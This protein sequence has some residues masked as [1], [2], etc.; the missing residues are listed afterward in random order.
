MLPYLTFFHF[1]VPMYGVCLAAG[2][3]VGAMIGTKRA[4]KRGGDVNDAII[5]IALAFSGA[6]VFAKIGYLIFSFGLQP[7]FAELKEG[8]FKV[9]VEEGGFMFYGGL[10]GGITVAYIFIKIQKLDVSVYI[11]SFVPVIPIGHAFGRL[12]CTCAG[13]CFGVPY[14]GFMAIRMQGMSVFPVQPLEAVLNVF[15]AWFLFS[16]T[17][18]KRGMAVVFIYLILYGIVRFSLEFL[19]GDLIRGIWWGLS[20]SQWISLATA[21]VSAGALLVCK[22]KKSVSEMQ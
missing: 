11:D 19:R 1:N 14:N 6:M 5:L 22:T 18:K 8:N 16:Y 7:L 10:L 17:R 9:L 13:C 15:I 2:L 12:G 21:L 4:I 20:T 3:L